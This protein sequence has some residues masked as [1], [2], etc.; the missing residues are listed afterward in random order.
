MISLVAC[1]ANIED[2]PAYLHTQRKSLERLGGDKVDH[3]RELAEG[4]LAPSAVLRHIRQLT[5][6]IVRSLSSSLL[7]S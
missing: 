7:R 4:Q 3:G 5:F 1:T 6:S 2:L